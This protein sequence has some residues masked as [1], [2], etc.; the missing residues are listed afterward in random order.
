MNAKRWPAAAGLLVL[1]LGA[2]ASGYFAY[3]HFA[4]APQPTHVDLASFQFTDLQDQPRSLQEWQGQLLLVNFW[5]SWCT[6]CR[7][8]IPMLLEV[9]E[10]YATQG[11]QIVGPAMD[12]PEVARQMQTVLKINYPVFPGSSEIVQAMDA[13]GDQIGALPFSV[14]IDAQGRIV[15]RKSG[16]LHRE[17]LVE[18]IEKH[19]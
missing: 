6:P 7:K 1:L 11:F 17:E 18:A 8:E 14:L 19:L 2:A 3:Q 16:E 9:Q 13:L 4:A 10:Q 15:M 12:E 5:A